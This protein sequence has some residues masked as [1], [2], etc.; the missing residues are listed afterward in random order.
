MTA[1]D[2]AVDDETAAM[3]EAVAR[4]AGAEDGVA[5]LGEQ[6]LRSLRAG[7]HQGVRHLLVRGDEGGISGYAQLEGSGQE[8]T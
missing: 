5:P 1:I 3:I 7:G 6:P 2:H 4:D 8:A